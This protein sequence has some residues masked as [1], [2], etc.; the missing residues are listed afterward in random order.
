[1]LNPFIHSEIQFKPKINNNFIQIYIASPKNINK[2]IKN[3]VATIIKPIQEFIEYIFSPT[4]RKKAP[5]K[6][7]SHRGYA[8]ALFVENCHS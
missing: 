8:L 5:C 4:P 3:Q 2:T 6:S 7:A 1:M